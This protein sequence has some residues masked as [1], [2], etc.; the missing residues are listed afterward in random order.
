MNLFGIAFTNPIMW[1][2]IFT[3]T[4]PFMVHLLT[5]R[6]L[7][8]LLFPTIQFLKTAK[9]N[10]SNL[11]R[12]RHIL[13][14]L[15]RTLALALLLATFLKPVYQ[16]GALA[17]SGDQAGDN[18]VIVILDAS[19]SMGYTGAGV[20][21]FSQGKVAAEEIIGHLGSGDLANV[22]LAAATPVSSFDAPKLNRHQLRQDIEAAKVSLERGDIDSAV[23]MALEQFRDLGEGGKEIHFVSDFQRTGWASVNYGRIPEDVKTVFVFVGEEDPA[24]GTITEVLVQPPY[25][26]VSEPVTITCKVANYSSKTREI[27]LELILYGGGATENVKDQPRFKR[28]LS[29]GPGMTATASF[30]LRL[31]AK[32]LYEGTVTIPND[33]LKPDNTRVFTV[34]VV[35]RMG[36]TILTDEQAR[37]GRD[38][39]PPSHRLIDVAMAPFT[40]KENTVVSTIMKPDA[41]DEFAAARSQG[42]IITGAKEF[43][44]DTAKNLMDY[45][46]DGGGILYFL[47][48]PAD[49]MNLDLLVKHSDKDLVLPFKLDAFRKRERGVDDEGRATFAEANYESP[50]LRKF[51]DSDSLAALSFYQYFATQRQK[52]EGQVLLRYDDGHVAL[53]EQ[54]LG[55]GTLLLANFSADLSSSDMAK[56]TVFVP[57][58]HEMIKAMRPQSSEGLAFSV[59]ESCSTTVTLPS[60]DAPVRFVSPS[61]QEISAGFRIHDNEGA[62]IIS[63]THEPGFYRVYTEDT[64]VGLMAVNVD[65]RESNLDA[66]SNDQ[67]QELSKIARERFFAA[68]GNNLEELRRL[69][70]G[71]PL[72]PYLLVAVLC[73]LALEQF[74]AFIWKR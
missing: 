56:H 44:E 8:T 55:L 27:P 16:V 13:L 5:R 62:V 32:A 1:A 70:E 25:P 20:T 63:Q 43:S 6:T 19:L 34:P 28:S 51:R 31:H 65:S 72:W 33:G 64:K 11:Y 18:A 4:I 38:T 14:L 7:V 40:G 29:I 54:N 22:I 35:D 42:V 10:Q 52:N 68:G 60:A 61:G 3:L 2:G 71:V 57:L 48:S 50:I 24:N 30:R 69:R 37:R 26:A 49:R 17:G 9:A 39:R 53:A 74:F 23:A 59:G 66:L 58:L 73:A 45:L 15:L 21:P 36:I 47:S 46:R 12:I 41:F 67:L